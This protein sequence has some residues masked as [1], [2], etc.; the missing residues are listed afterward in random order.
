MKTKLS[1]LVLVIGMATYAIAQSSGTTSS[2][3][4][5]QPIKIGG[6]TQSG[7]TG[8][9]TQSGQ[10]GGST[11]SVLP[12]GQTFRNDGL[13]RTI[14]SQN[15]NQLNRS[16]PPQNNGII[17]QN[18]VD[19]TNGI[20][21]NSPGYNMTNGGAGN[22]F[23]TNSFGNFGRTNRTDPNSSNYL[24]N[25]NTNGMNVRTNRLHWWNRR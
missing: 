22:G 4:P 1:T 3:A 15:D 8:S 5:S 2:S 24:S 9:S 12:D 13:N 21:R 17:N 6:S 19:Y 10:T 11:Q 20:N 14:P 16:I 25:V 7:Q 23:E 18:R